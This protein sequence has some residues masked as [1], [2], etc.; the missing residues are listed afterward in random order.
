MSPLNL[1]APLE[2]LTL[3]LC[4]TASLLLKWIV[5]GASAG[6][7][8]EPPSLG[9][10][11]APLDAAAEGA[12]VG[13]A[14]VQPGAVSAEQAAAVRATA[15]S[16]RANSRRRMGTSGGHP[17]TLAM[18]LPNASKRCREPSFRRAGD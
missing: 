15:E 4:G 14:Y 7:V 13:A 17:E 6:A 12:S 2:S 5:N 11:D 18:L 1:L 10:A 8:D 16:A 9:A 3:T